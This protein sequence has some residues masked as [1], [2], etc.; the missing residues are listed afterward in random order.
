MSYLKSPVE[1]LQQAN[2]IENVKE[3]ADFLRPHMRPVMRVLLACVYNENIKF[4]DYSDVKYKVLK[5]PRGIVD[6]TL[7]HEARRLYIFTDSAQ[8]PLQ[9]KK[10]KLIQILE[11]LHEEES[12][13]LFNYIVK[14]KLPW[15]KITH[16]FITKSFPEILNSNIA[17]R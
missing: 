5:N 8:L 17:P 4:P 10:A 12:N 7:D 16:S 14:K 13:L 2:D 3:R 1:I 9:R 15:S 6:T 11:G